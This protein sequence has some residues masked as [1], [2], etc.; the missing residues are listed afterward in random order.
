M[1]EH[2]TASNPPIWYQ[3]KRGLA[4]NAT[5]E[6]WRPVVGYE[7]RYEVSNKGRVRSLDRTVVT[8]HGVVKRHRGRIMKLHQTDG[9]HHGLRLSGDSGQRLVRVHTLVLEAFV[10]PR[11]AGLVGCHNDGNG[12]NN[13]LSNLRW[14]TH[15]ENNF[16][17]VR[18]GVHGQARK[19]HCPQ[20]HAYTSEN[21]YIQRDSRAAWPGRKCRACMKSRNQLN[22]QRRSESRRQRRDIIAAFR[23]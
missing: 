9:G 7:S 22:S 17:L 19:T 14:D 1:V 20:G 11:P 12:S 13:A 8:K 5:H 2:P 23:R 16:D 10:G 6:E 3:Q 15:G 18:H 21:T 4:V